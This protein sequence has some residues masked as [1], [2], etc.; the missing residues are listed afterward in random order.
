MEL[1]RNFGVFAFFIIYTFLYPLVSLCRAA[2]K[3]DEALVLAITYIVYLVIAGTN[4]LLLSSTGMLVLLTMFSA[5]KGYAK[6]CEITQRND[7]DNVSF[8]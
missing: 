6:K 8:S 5:S 2:L 3:N 4:P 1:W 7:C